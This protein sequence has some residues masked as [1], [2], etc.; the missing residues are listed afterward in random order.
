MVVDT[1]AASRA[2]R[3][4]QIAERLQ[5]VRV[6]HRAGIIDSHCHASPVWYEPVESLL[7]QMDRNGVRGAILIQMQ[8]QTNNDYQAECLR[9]Y[10][11]RFA[12]V[13]IV[14]TAR[15]DAPRAL[16]RLAAAGASGVRLGAPARSPGDDPLAIWRAA[17]RLGLAVSCAGGSADFASDDFARLVEALPGLAIVI[18]HLG[19]VS[20]PDDD[21]AQRETR[22]RVFALARY[23]NLSIKV[24][25]LGEFCRRAL[26][27]PDDPFPFE[28]PI[29]PYLDLAY[30]TFGPRRMMWGSDYPPVSGR[31]GYQNALRLAMEQ[32]AAKSQEDRDQIFGGTALSAFPLRS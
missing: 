26:P 17:E 16:E 23:P 32:F 3:P 31:E 4:P 25:G 5:A 30:D 19:S 24:P 1:R 9:R 2:T 6:E 13:V 29:P 27:V 15:P 12:S 7:A 21:E 22:R 8:G 18:E 10:P 11:G 14:D 20:R 28:R